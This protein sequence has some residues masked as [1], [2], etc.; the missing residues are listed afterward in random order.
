MSVYKELEYAVDVEKIIKDIDCILKLTE[1][2]S[3]QIALQYADNESWHA[4]I[5]K[6]DYLK[7]S[8]Q[9]FVKY[10]S[11]LE[12]T[13]IKQLLESLN[14]PVAHARIMNLPPKTCYTTHVDY[15]TRY[16]IPVTTKP[17]QTY[18]HFPDKETTVRMY[19]GKMYWTNTH[20]LHNFINGT[21]EN[22]IHIIFNDAREQKN[23]NNP[24]LEM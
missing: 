15:Y 5:G 10:H 16:H 11:A 13:Y 9:D 7:H 2:K 24:Y 14:F 12:N 8:E 20:E 4:G 17:L 3:N 23:L 1:Y 18:M 19:P 21:F 22:R 6:S